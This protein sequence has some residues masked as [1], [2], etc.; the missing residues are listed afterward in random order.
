MSSGLRQFAR[1]GIVG[2]LNTGVYYLCYL[3]LRVVVGYLVAHW[4]AWVVSTYASFFLNCRFTYNVPPT[5]RRAALYPLSNAPNLVATTLGVVVLI[6]TFDVSQKW[7]PFIAGVLAI[8]MTFLVQRALMQ[9]SWA[10]GPLAHV[11]DESSDSD[12][13]H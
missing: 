5:W 1:F 7:A 4:I 9:T 10:N 3:P 12:V 6:E 11:M 13:V 8:P 2:V